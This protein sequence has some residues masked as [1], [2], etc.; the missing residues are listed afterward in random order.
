MNMNTSLQKPQSTEKWPYLIFIFIILILLV[1]FFVIQSRGK[2]D[3]G[4]SLEQQNY[5]VYDESLAEP[6]KKLSVWNI[7]KMT[8][9]LFWPFVVITA[10]GIMLIIY[11]LLR[12]YQEKSR[13]RLLLQGNVKAND[14]RGLMRIIQFSNFNRASRLMHQMLATFNKTKRAE[15]IG[16]DVN[17]FL[18]TERESFETFSRVT[19]FLSDT[20]GALGLLG[21]VWGIFQTFHAGKLDGPTI[22][23]GMS[24]SLVTTLVGLIISLLLNMGATYVFALFNGHLKLLSTKAEELRQVLLNLEKKTMSQPQVVE[25]D[26]PNLRMAE[27]EYHRQ[28]Q[29]HNKKHM[30]AI[31]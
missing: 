31:F 27:I 28:R 29:K 21:T 22:L 3:Q 16:D 20:A 12:E 13:S 2:K 30:D 6:E 11:H 5:Q 23:Q 19:G 26:S 1:G 7:I 24:I 25:E 15:P 14:I 9:W 17:Q 4:I 8:D 10:A 18:S